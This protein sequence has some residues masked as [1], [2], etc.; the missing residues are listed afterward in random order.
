M[1]SAAAFARP[2]G[3]FLADAMKGRLS[4][5]IAGAS[6]VYGRAISREGGGM[7]RIAQK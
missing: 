5:V 4:P 2:R 3:A 6:Y 7:R 1:R